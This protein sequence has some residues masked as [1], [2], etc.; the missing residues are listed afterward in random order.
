MTVGTYRRLPVWVHM[1]VYLYGKTYSVSKLSLSLSL[2]QQP[3]AGQG[4]LS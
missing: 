4:R 1:Y 2:A 3:N